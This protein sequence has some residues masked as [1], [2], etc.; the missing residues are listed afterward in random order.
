MTRTASPAIGRWGA[1]PD[2]DRL[3]HAA[4]L[5]RLPDA[6]NVVKR[7]RL[8]PVRARFYREMW[9]A[10]AR[11]IGASCTPVGGGLTR[12]DRDGYVTFV[13]GS[14]LMLDSA[15]TLAMIGDREVSFG[16]IAGHGIRTPAYRVIHRRAGPAADRFLAETGAVVVKPLRGTGGGR[17]VTTGVNDAA[18]LSRAMRRAAR[19]GRDLVLEEQVP[20]DYYRLT[21][22][23]GDMIDAVRRDPPALI[24][25]GDHTIRQLVARENGVRLRGRVPTALSPLLIDADMV[26][27]LTEDGR[28]LSDVPARG[29][30]VVVKRA[31]NENAAAQNRSVLAQVPEAT[32]AR[33][34][35]LAL[36]LGLRFAGIDMMTPDLSAPLGPDGPVV[37][38][39]NGNP[40]LHHHL[41]VANRGKAP[42]VPRIVLEHLFNNRAGVVRP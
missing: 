8:A 33:L 12:I 36:D 18:K 19:F 28:R 34:G 24:G 39:I 40:G 4:K 16:L 1:L 10:T 7:R 30:R 32:A 26:N 14:D 25:T 11:D 23:D 9:T 31:V 42:D 13:R 37:I 3:S 20:G 21:F 2:L 15:V 6:L 17:G 27:R 22:L 29:E 5:H 41:L 35:Q 38:E